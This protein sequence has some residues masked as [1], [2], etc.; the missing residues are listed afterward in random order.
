MTG[1][2]NTG[3]QAS[4]IRAEVERELEA[5]FSRSIS[6]AEAYGTDFARLWRLAATHAQ[7]GKLVRPMLLLEVYGAVRSAQEAT[8]A[9]GSSRPLGPRGAPDPAEV[10]RIAAAVEALHF[11]FLLH[12]DVID[13]DV[14]RRGQLNLIGEIAESTR[15][16]A[17]PGGARRWAQ[18]GGIL[19]GNLLLSSAH[20]LFARALVPAEL[21]S[22]LLDLLEHTIFETSAGEYTD[23]G[24]ADGVIGADLATVLTMTRQKTAS[25]SFQLPLRAAA[26]LAGGSAAL[27]SRLSAAGAHLGLA[28]QLQDDLLSTF[29][30]PVAHGKDAYS[31]LREGK[32]TAL[33]CFARMSGSWPLME[34]DFGDPGLS[35]QRAE[36]LRECLRECGAEDFV[37]G[38]IQE[39]LS[40]FYGVLAGAGA[41]GAEEIP[42]EVR[43]VL[44]AL[45]ARIEGRRS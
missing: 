10:L 29:G 36:Q 20:Q 6:T 4:V 28:Y 9:S 33:I 16:E 45:V 7:G 17:R 40:A 11:S 23:V 25:Y 37:L 24:L 18:A 44:L 42:A 31:D 30:D 26:I 5:L 13:G 34:A 38:L 12:D 8:A 19:A 14:R 22:R 35:P 15:E 41:D 27:E 43:E 1:L 32:Q 39:Q 2:V 3:F 21:R